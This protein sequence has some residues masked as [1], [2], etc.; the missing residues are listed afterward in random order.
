MTTQERSPRLEGKVAIVTGGGAREP[1][2]RT[3][4]GKAISVLLARE[5]ATVLVA[6]RVVGQ[7]ME[8]LSAIKA[9]GGE[10]SV[11]EGDVSNIDDCR[12]MTEAAWER[13]GRLDILVNNVG[14]I[15]PKGTAVEVDEEGWDRLMSVN[16]KGMMLTSKFAIPRMI[17]G[18]GGSIINISSVGGLR[19]SP[20][21]GSI[22]Y[23]VSKA[24]VIGLTTQ[25]AVQH[26]RDNV[27]V[28]CIV[29]G[30]I[31]TPMVAGNLTDERRE[32]ER[33][34]I[35]LGRE[36]TAWNIAWAA[37]YLASDEASWVTG[38]VLP[39]DGGY[40]ATAPGELLND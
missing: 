33:R 3:G 39:V 20:R 7:A 27:R 24:G 36:G 37:V 30:N 8:T 5:G 10:V 40:L 26:G 29:P 4:T 22:T 12:R 38:I 15:G 19:S 25:M 17:E 31:Y 23:G 11:F 1:G 28:N 35:P 9:E 13:Y 2:P 14:I 16:L 32:Q 18:G 6:D 34:R 21:W